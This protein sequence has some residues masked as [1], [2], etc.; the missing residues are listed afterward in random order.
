MHACSWT[1]VDAVPSVLHDACWRRK[2]SA[3]RLHL[4]VGLARWLCAVRH[5]HAVSGRAHVCVGEGGRTCRG[6]CTE[7]R[8]SRPAGG[9]RRRLCLCVAIQHAAPALRGGERSLYED[10]L[11]ADWIGSDKARARRAGS[12][13]GGR[14]RVRAAARWL[15]ALN[16]PDKTRRILRFCPQH[17]ACARSERVAQESTQ[18]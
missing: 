14:T 9:A 15:A 12:T 7:Q 8:Q 17:L 16:G 1:L 4:A 3:G 2:G 11:A 13:T 10:L 6:R 18:P 5:G